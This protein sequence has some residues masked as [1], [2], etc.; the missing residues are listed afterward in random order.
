MT[1]IL[2]LS[3]IADY[4]ALKA[5]WR[6]EDVLVHMLDPVIQSDLL[7]EERGGREAEDRDVRTPLAEEPGK[8]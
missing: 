1:R 8:L 4:F 6:F 3:Y 2:D 7:P 5:E